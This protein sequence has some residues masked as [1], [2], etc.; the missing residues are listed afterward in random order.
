LYPIDADHTRLVSRIRWS[1]SWNKPGQLAFD[2]FTEFTDHLA[3]RKILQGVKGRVEERIEPMALSTVEFFIYLGT[4]LIFVTA[5]LLILIRPLTWQGW[6]AALAAGSVW[7]V[8]WYAPVPACSGAILGLLSIWGLVHNFGGK[9][10]IPK[11]L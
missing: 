5:S 8:S 4:V 3:I 11:H 10:W 7:L 2:L 9:T 1:H 6:L